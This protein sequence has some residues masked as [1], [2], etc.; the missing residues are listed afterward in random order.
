[1]QSV[2]DC[3]RC[4]SDALGS[5]AKLASTRQL[6]V[7]RTPDAHRPWHSLDG[8]VRQGSRQAQVLL[9]TR[10]RTLGSSHS[11]LFTHS[12][13]CPEKKHPEQYRLS[14]EEGISNY[15]NFWYEYFWRSWPSND[16]S[17]FHLI[18]CLFLHY[19][20]KSEPTKYEL[21]WTEMRQKASPTLSI[22]TWKRIDRF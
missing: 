18:W 6:Q 12:T 3:V 9:D 21:K 16:R 17:T 8:G 20:G 1:M 13:S 19:L 10:R 7:S 22:V 4:R 15:N 14:L 5:N 2:V 11:R